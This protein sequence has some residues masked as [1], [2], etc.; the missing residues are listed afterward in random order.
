MDGDGFLDDETVLDQLADV[1]PWVGVGDLADLVR[2]KPN[3]YND[4]NVNERTS[5]RYELT[6]STLKHI[7]EINEEM[8][9]VNWFIC[10]K[11]E[12]TQEGNNRKTTDRQDRSKGSYTS[13][14]RKYFIE[15]DS[16][17]NA[18]FN[19]IANK[20]KMLQP[21]SCHI[22]WHRTPAVSAA[23]AHSS[24]PSDFPIWNKQRW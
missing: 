23:L 13:Y 11:Y 3:L 8:N 18:S 7:I 19:L 9:I 24:W 12:V 14:K 5:V 6:E 2:V 20:L 22:S 17:T 16:F 15:D 10:G 21:C 1:L 4:R